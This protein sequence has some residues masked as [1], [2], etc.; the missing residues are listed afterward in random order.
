LQ[1]DRVLSSWAAPIHARRNVGS[2]N[3]AELATCVVND[4]NPPVH[5]RHVIALDQYEG[6]VDTFV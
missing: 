1:A 6:V 4:S 3:Q 5:D 2:A